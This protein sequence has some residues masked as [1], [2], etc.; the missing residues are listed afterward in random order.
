MMLLKAV[1]PLSSRFHIR[2]EYVKRMADVFYWNNN[3]TI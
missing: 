3:F 1:P 2:I